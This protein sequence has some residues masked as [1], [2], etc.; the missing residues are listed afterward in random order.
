MQQLYQGAVAG[1]SDQKRILVAA[2]F[3]PNNV[4]FD[5]WLNYM[6]ETTYDKPAALGG[7][8]GTPTAASAST[9]GGADSKW[10]EAQDQ[11]GRPY[12]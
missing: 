4:N 8:G 2:P 3:T 11:A 7:S 5:S 9:R 6:Q 12:W 1:R 10:R